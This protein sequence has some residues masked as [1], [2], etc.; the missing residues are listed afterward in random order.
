M[1]YRITVPRKLETVL[2]YDGSHFIL[3]APF[4]KD[5]WIN[6]LAAGSWDKKQGFWK[7]PP[8]IVYAK[9]VLEQIPDVGVSEDAS[10]ALRAPANGDAL[11]RVFDNVRHTSRR[12]YLPAQKIYDEVFYPYQCDAVFWLIA[13]PKQSGLLALSPGLGKTIITLVAARLL[14]LQRVLIIAPRPLL[15]TWENEQLKFFSELFTTR[16]H[17]MPPPDD[18][19]GWVLTNYETVVGA[20]EKLPKGQKGPEKIIHGYAAEY[21]KVDWDLVVLDESVLVKS[22]DSRRF[23]VLER[24]RKTFK[25]RKRWWELSGS[26]VTRYYD[27]LWAQLHLIDPAGFHS[28]WRFANRFCYV[29]QDVWGTQISGNRASIDI[30]DDLKD[31]VLVINQEEVLP[32]LP[33]EIP[34]LVEVDLR[35]K[36]AKAHDEM[37][38]YFITQLESGSEV[39]ANIILA[40]LTRLQQITSNLIN[41]PGGTDESAK[42]DALVEM[43]KA[44]AYAFPAIVWTHW[45]PGAQMLWTRLGKLSNK[46]DGQL[47]VEWI[48]GTDTEAEARDAEE[49]FEAY[50]AGKIDILILGLEVGKFGHNLQITRTAI[51]IDKTW[52]ADAYVQSMKRVK[53]IGLNHRP[54]VITIKAPGTVDELVEDNLTGKFPGIATITNA[55][56]ASMLHHLRGGQA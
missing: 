20:A 24:L 43:T 39:K 46:V 3:H 29:L 32:D 38:T 45:I 54:V 16:R 9:T 12:A 27:D 49:K 55:N 19:F 7:L 11:L 36:Q 48:H 13:G 1:S 52:D 44:R 4:E 33:E 10:I 22:R 42:M 18:V 47:R 41:L 15:R 40:Q 30:R 35:P 53:R 25:G 6:Q 8:Y 34:Q 14:G 17:G 26:P 2:D 56:L 5:S 21:M 50:M 31:V 23:K 28:Y 37:L 51:Y